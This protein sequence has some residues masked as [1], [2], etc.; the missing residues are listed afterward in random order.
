MHIDEAKLT[1]THFVSE[2]PMVL[3][4]EAEELLPLYHALLRAGRSIASQ[5]RYRLDHGSLSELQSFCQQRESFVKPIALLRAC[6][7]GGR[8][9]EVGSSA[10]AISPQLTG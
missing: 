6:K 1:T 7:Q 5:S 10:L 2:T 4:V 3:I 8:A 9:I